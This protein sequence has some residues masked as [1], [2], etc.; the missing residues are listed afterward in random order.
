[1]QGD[2]EH[3]LPTPIPKYP[4]E[5]DGVRAVRKTLTTPLV[6]RH[7]GPAVVAPRYRLPLGAHLSSQTPLLPRGVE[8]IA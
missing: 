2:H 6:P 4:A 3:G 1:V 5:G 8:R 7:A